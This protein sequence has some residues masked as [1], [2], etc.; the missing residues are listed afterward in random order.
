MRVGR[1]SFEVLGAR[2][3]GLPVKTTADATLT[4]GERIDFIASYARAPLAEPIY[5]A[6]ALR[7]GAGQCVVFVAV[8]VDE[9]GRVSEVVP[10]WQRIQLGGAFASEFLAAAKAAVEQWN[11]SPAHD[12]YYRVAPGTEDE[13]IRTE[14]VLQTFEVKFVFATPENVR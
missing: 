9:T 12:V 13:Y 5:P 10:S 6:A 4:T 11:F 1:S 2:A 7:A 3:N 14:A 8:T